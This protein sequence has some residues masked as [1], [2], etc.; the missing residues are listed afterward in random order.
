MRNSEIRI[1]QLSIGV[2]VRASGQ[3]PIGEIKVK[4]SF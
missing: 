3:L 4:D 1:K 2:E